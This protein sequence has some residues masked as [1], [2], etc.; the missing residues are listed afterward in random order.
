MRFSSAS[1]YRRLP[2]Q[3]RNFN[4][5]CT[6]LWLGADHLL[7]VH[8]R[9]YSEDYKRFYYRDIQAIT[10]RPTAR[11]T[12]WNILWVSLLSGC[13]VLAWTTQEHVPQIVWGSLAA[14]WLLCLLYNSLAGPTCVSYLQTA[15]QSV[16]LPSLHRRHLFRKAFVLL[17]P[18]ILQAQAD[19]PVVSPALMPPA[20]M[21]PSHPLPPQGPRQG[22]YRGA[23]HAILFGFLFLDGLLA[24]LTMFYASPVLFWGTWGLAFGVLLATLLAL[25]SQTRG[26][27]QT[28]R[29]VTWSTLG[30]ASLIYIARALPGMFLLNQSF[31]MQGTASQEAARFLLATLSS[32]LQ[33]DGSLARTLAFISLIGGCSLSLLGFGLL[34]RAW[35]QPAPTLPPPALEATT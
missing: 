30:Y 34:Y 9:H 7:S 24:G 1:P 23:W 35:R 31:I 28:L 6:R 22:L 26:F 32:H 19:L 17:Q 5:F 13:A 25:V 12:W 15:V 11:R 33:G 29:L 2:G 3:R 18:L 8:N 14:V 4:G 20:P 16:P 27:P 21:R 10:V